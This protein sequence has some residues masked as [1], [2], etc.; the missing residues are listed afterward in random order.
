M[1]Q[2]QGKGASPDG[3]PA[4]QPPAQAP[5]GLGDTVSVPSAAIF[6]R[7][8]EVAKERYPNGANATELAAI[9]R[10]VCRE[11]GLT[12]TRRPSAVVT[13]PNVG[14]H[15]RLEL[16]PTDQQEEARRACAAA[17]AL[18]FPNWPPCT[19][20][21]FVCYRCQ[22]LAASAIEARRAIDSEAGVVGDESAVAKRDAQ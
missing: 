13:N 14:R 9:V 10:D 19:D 16:L 1:Q 17:T 12:K 5:A 8:E 4:T 2:E 20:K 11:L 21:G 7:A 6:A 15:N 22:D 18:N 3:D